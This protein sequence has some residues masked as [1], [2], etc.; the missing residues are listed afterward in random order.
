LNRN[1]FSSAWSITS[2]I[3]QLYRPNGTPAMRLIDVTL[4]Y[5][6]PFQR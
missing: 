6:R 2:P 3:D 5:S 4:G 1:A